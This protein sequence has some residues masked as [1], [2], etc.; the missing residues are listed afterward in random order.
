MGYLEIEKEKRYFCQLIGREDK[1]AGT[2]SVA[3]GDIRVRLVQL[4][5][6]FHLDDAANLR[7]RTED[8]W[9]ASLFDNV[10]GSS[11]RHGDA[12]FHEIISNTA[13]LG[14][15][16]WS[17][18]D[19][20]A[21][22]SFRVPEADPLFEWSPVFE[23]VA[24]AEMG[25]LET[26]LFAAAALDEKVNGHLLLSGTMRS[27]TP[28]QIQPLISVEFQERRTLEEMRVAV[29]RVVRF[30]SCGTG[31][32]LRPKNIAIS[33]YSE[34]E[35]RDRVA[36][37]EP[38]PQHS[39][40]YH[41]RENAEP[42]R[43]EPFHSLLSL[44]DDACREAF[45]SALREWIARDEEWR[46]ATALMMAALE[47]QGVM[48]G[49]RLLNAARWLEETPGAKAAGVVAAEHAKALGKLVDKWAEKLGYGSL[50]GR[51]KN[52]LSNV[53]L[54]SNRERFT[55][56]VTEVR[57]VFGDE[58]VDG[59]MVVW[60]L[61]AMKLRGPAAH[62]ANTGIDTDLAVFQRAVYALECLNLL[63]MLKDLPIGND[64]VGRARRHPL[65]EQ[66]RLS[67]IGHTPTTIRAGPTA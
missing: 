29:H 31:V 30:L 61:E 20:V 48:S 54:E 60:L 66:Y 28:E 21:R 45:E 49:E 8:D 58:I 22:V 35:F 4:D 65:V 33:R 19:R 32:H 18:D 38:I 37:H 39:L 46:A 34:E 59:G 27:R 12:Y 26:G 13:V 23:R 6:F 56:L 25:S 1:L 63:L 5:E 17:D 47:T 55:R 2:F 52:A 7:V 62:R 40:Y 64:A 11:G 24:D 43:C 57:D 53:A 9:T 15:D 42:A 44:R 3:G 10:P 67:C 41:G 16:A 36:A 51:F 14:D 50:G